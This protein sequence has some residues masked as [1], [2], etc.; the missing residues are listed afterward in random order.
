MPAVPHDLPDAATYREAVELARTAAAAYHRGDPVLL[1]DADY[2]QL[3]ALIAATEDAHPDWTVDHSPVGK[4]AG[5]AAV[6]GDIAHTT[7]MLSLANAF[8]HSQV[9]DW[10]TRLSRTL[11]RPPARL[12]VE[13]KLD[14]VAL[15]A[16]YTQ[17]QLTQLATRGDGEHGEDVTATRVTIAGLP[18]TL[19]EPVDVLVRG[20]VLLSADDFQQANQLR[21]Q[22]GQQPLVN[23]RNGAAGLLRNRDAPYQ[24]P[25]TFY[26]YELLTDPLPASQQAA[27]S[28]LTALG[29]ATSADSSAGVSSAGTVDDALAAV[30]TLGRRRNELDIAIDGA[31]IKA[32]DGAARHAGATGTAPRWAVAYKFAPELRMSVLERID[33]QVGRTGA[34]TPVAKITPV[35]VG[36]TTV[37][38]VGLH[39]ADEVARKD[40]RVGDTVWVQR[41]G[42]VIPQ[43]VGPVLAQRPEHTTPYQPSRDCPRCR[44]PLHTDA[45][46]WRCPAGR[47]CGQ[48]EALLYA[49]GRDALDLDGLGRQVLTAAV[50]AGVVTRH[51]DL[52]TLQAADLADLVAGGRRVGEATAQRIADAAQAAW[53]LPLHRHLTALGL[54]HLGRRLG[55]RLAAAAG[56]LDGVRALTRAQIAAVDGFGDG[57]ADAIAAELGALDD[58]LA[59]IR[60]LGI[61]PAAASHVPAGTNAPL[62]GQTVVVTGTIDGWS[63]RQLE[64]LI[65]RLGGTTSGSVS[66]NTSLV[67]VGANAG[68]K[69]AKAAKLGVATVDGAAFVAE[70]GSR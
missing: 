11:G 7:P 8:N 2:D 62:A 66:S 64:Q 21:A 29:V 16:W 18:A 25:M 26:A 54:R 6:S 61:N 1:D 60:Q 49:A 34:V 41:A 42:D 63:R 33:V 37:S 69:A 45:K 58:E 4:V 67:V 22:Y 28:R 68:A 5:G 39:N 70:H 43:I 17:G 9:V 23:P 51:R 10:H 48:V 27:L 3:V 20:E 36:G 55:R 56:D 31:V 30:E 15:A 47:A 32:D 40:L 50:E 38:S 35:F 19:T 52:Y 24:A 59:A 57:R 53:Q 12:L 44:R 13:P 46:V 14:G 65:V